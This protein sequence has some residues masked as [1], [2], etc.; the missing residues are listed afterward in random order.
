MYDGSTYNYD[1]TPEHAS[2]V[3]GAALNE[4]GQALHTVEDRT[5]P[6]HTDANGNPR[7]WNGIPVTKDEVQAVE[8]HNSEEANITAE[9]MANSVRAARDAFGQTFGQQALQEAQ[10][11]PKQD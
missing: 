2:Q 11:P 7:D 3:G 8:Q 9:Q 6:A 1:G 10:T 4:F 5:S